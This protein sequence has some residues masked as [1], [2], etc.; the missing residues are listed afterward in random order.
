ME[1]CTQSWRAQ[2]YQEQSPVGL[3]FLDNRLDRRKTDS[4]KQMPILWSETHILV[5]T[6]SQVHRLLDSRPERFCWVLC[7]YESVFK[8]IRMWIVN[9]CLILPSLSPNSKSKTTQKYNRGLGKV[10]SGLKSIIP[11]PS[12]LPL[13]VPQKSP[14]GLSFGLLEDQFMASFLLKSNCPGLVP[15]DS[16]S[17][18]R[19]VHTIAMKY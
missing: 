6:E 19:K 4:R 17:S 18:L 9:W 16:N 15:I 11:I 1:L 8:V 10:V 13:K 3:Q 12:T 5:A 14:G 7:T 2:G